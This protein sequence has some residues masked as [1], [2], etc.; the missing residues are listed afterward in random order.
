MRIEVTPHHALLA[1]RA[2]VC[3]A[4]ILAVAA[5]IRLAMPPRLESAHTVI[6]ASTRVQASESMSA[7]R[8]VAQRRAAPA[9]AG[10][11]RNPFTV[12][13]DTLAAPSG[14]TAPPAPPKAVPPMTLVGTIEHADGGRRAIVQIGAEAKL[15]KVGQTIDQF[16]VKAIKRGQVRVASSDTSLTLRMTA[17]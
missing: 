10:A 2:A 5:G 16:V 8:T 13:G 3:F 4:A 12:A 6:P 1:A 9:A 17:Q 11:L 7:I 14:P 15:L